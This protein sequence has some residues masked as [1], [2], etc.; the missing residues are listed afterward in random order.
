MAAFQI[1]NQ[2]MSPW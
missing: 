2:E 1:I